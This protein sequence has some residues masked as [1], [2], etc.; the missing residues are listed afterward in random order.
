[1]PRQYVGID[2]MCARNRTHIEQKV[3]WRSLAPDADSS[4]R[5]VEGNDANLTVAELICSARRY[6]KTNVT[7]S[8]PLQ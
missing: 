2:G 4:C 1:M 5:G 7:E 8:Q 6:C 3:D